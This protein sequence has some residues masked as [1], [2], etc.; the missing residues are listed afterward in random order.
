MM[1]KIRK[2]TPLLAMLAL[3]LVGCATPVRFEVTR[4]PTLD[5]TGIQRVAVMPF[6][7]G[8][9][10]PDRR[11]MAE[12][13]TNETSSRLAATNQFSMVP[14][15]AVNDA[16]A[17]GEPAS[18]VVDA[19]FTG[20]I[21]GLVLTTT[22]RLVTRTV[23]GQQVQVTN[24]L[25]EVSVAFEYYFVNAH[26]NVII[27][28]IRRT[29]RSTSSNDNR[30]NLVDYGMLANRVIRD[31]LVSFNRDVAPH[32]IR[33]TRRLESAENRD[34]RPAMDAAEA[35]VRGQNFVA[36]RQ[37]F[38]NIWEQHGSVSAAINASILFE[39][40][41]D[42]EDGI[43][44]MEN[45]F[46]IT[47]N[48]RVTQVIAR[49][50]RELAGAMAVGALDDDRTPAERIA[51]HA[52]DEVGRFISE[53]ATLWIHNTATT[54]VG[55]ANDVVDNMTAAFLNSGFTVVERGMIDLFAVERGLHLEGQVADEDFLAVGRMAGANTL[56]VVGISGTG[57]AR[58]LQ[59]R[60]LD[61]ETG[62]IRMQSGTG[63]AWR[64]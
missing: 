1:G 25:R 44:F 35:Q 42:L 55:L 3:I 5:I 47:G 30:N 34:L 18:T 7:P 62:T 33:L 53:G 9:V 57:Q 6:E 36:A 52:V 40:T 51:G 29:G 63:V 27:G 23:Q 15:S 37:S 31:Q 12:W 14:A 43:Y 58:R 11:Q 45:V 17:R 38:I 16:R 46:E 64:L 2:A 22:P 54:D 21:T 61:M 10:T 13:L 20:R 39:A 24:Y 49:L 56:V 26:T 41:G 32:P 4:P 8:I 19:T 50:N 28:P 60:V 59:V 48:P